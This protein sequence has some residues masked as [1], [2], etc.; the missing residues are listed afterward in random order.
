VAQD[1]WKSNETLAVS[2]SISS[3]TDLLAGSASGEIVALLYSGTSPVWT[4]LSED[5]QGGSAIA[6][7]PAAGN[8][9]PGWVTFPDGARPKFTSGLSATLETGT[10]NLIAYYI[11]D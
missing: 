2:A 9:V 6:R 4:V 8:G 5:G 1:Q 3:S 11:L 10:G 7:L